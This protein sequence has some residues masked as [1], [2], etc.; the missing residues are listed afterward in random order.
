M[1]LVDF[2]CGDEVYGASPDLRE[3]LE[4]RGQAYVLRV[5][6]SFTVALAGGRTLTCAQAVKTLLK[7]KR[8]WEIR[9]AGRGSRAGGGRPGP[10]SGPAPGSTRCSSDV[11]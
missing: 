2:I 4:S 7:G 1:E 6:S 8:S 5:A 10:G 9:S 3:Y 11:T